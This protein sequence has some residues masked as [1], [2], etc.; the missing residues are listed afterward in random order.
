MSGTE[1]GY[2][3]YSL[4]TA[5]PTGWADRLSHPSG[6]TLTLTSYKGPASPPQGVSTRTCY[7]FSLPGAAAGAPVKPCLN[8]SSGLLSISIDQRIQG[9]WLVTVWF[10]SC[11]QGGLRPG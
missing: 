8:F 4:H 10:G 3:A 9:P 6:L 11:A 2:C 1:A 7:M 5:P